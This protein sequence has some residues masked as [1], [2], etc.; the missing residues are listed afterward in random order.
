MQILQ[1][2]FLAGAVCCVN[3]CCRTHLL[4]VVKGSFQLVYNFDTLYF[5]RILDQKP[6][7]LKE[8]IVNFWD[9]LNFI[10]F[11]LWKKNTVQQ[12]SKLSWQIFLSFKDI[13]V[14]FLLVTC[15]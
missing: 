14:E 12:V 10:F 13:K 8:A 11:F 4:L 7:I 1:E 3:V 15:I 2:G 5:V 9:I 6:V